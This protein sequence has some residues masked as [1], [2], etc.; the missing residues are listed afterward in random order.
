MYAPAV[1]GISKHVKNLTESNYVSA[2]NVS[3]SL[4]CAGVSH[5]LTG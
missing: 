4:I 1:F 3:K 2:D 5:Q